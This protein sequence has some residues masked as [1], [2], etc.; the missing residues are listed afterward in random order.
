MFS[1]DVY[2]NNNISKITLA[3]L[4]F[5][6][7]GCSNRKISVIDISPKH[8]KVQMPFMLAGRGIIIN[9][10]WG[11]EKKH[12][13]LCLDNNSPS[14]IKSSLIQYDQSFIKSSNLG[15]K[16]TTAD[17]SPIQG[18]VG[19]CDSLSFENILFRN[20][21]F[22]VMPD[23]SKDNKN[24]DGVFGIDVMSKGI[25]KIDFKNSELTFAS[26]IDSFTEINQA[27]VFSATFD[28][29]SI[30]VNVDFGNSNIKK[31][32]I[33]LGY[34][35]Y[36]IMPLKEFTEINSSNKIS[37]SLN[38]FNTPASEN[39]V[40]NIS[41]SDTV[42]INHE[43]FFTFVSSN[44]M[45]KNRLIGLEFFKKFEYVIFDFVNKRMYLPKKVW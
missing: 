32:T 21:P 45:V 6:A 4:I 16:T 34:N 20:I 36:M 37:F 26:S 35:G 9:T 10:Y 14:W 39:I 11:S 29:Q 22:Y 7:F 15:F 24:D 43:W 41:I 17:G 44:I 42:N 18:D 31:M 38:R 12:H 23:N 2:L 30:T 19:I 27:D 1:I 13:V 28:Q 3:I 5:V 40:K 33:D 8:F 25:W